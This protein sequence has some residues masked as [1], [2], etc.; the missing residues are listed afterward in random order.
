MAVSIRG[1]AAH[2]LSIF[3]I[4]AVRSIR[5]LLILC[6]LL[7]IRPALRPLVRP[8]RMKLQLLRNIVHYVGQYLLGAGD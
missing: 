7:L 6:N 3:E 2:G 5:R 1:L 4:L 8:R